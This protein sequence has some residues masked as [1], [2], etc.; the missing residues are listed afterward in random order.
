MT[1]D[2]K[3]LTINHNTTLAY[4][5]LI[6]CATKSFIHLGGCLSH[7]G[8]SDDGGLTADAGMSFGCGS[9]VKFSNSGSL[10]HLPTRTPSRLQDLLGTVFLCGVSGSCFGCRFHHFLPALRRTWSPSSLGFVPISTQVSLDSGNIPA[11]ILVAQVAV[12]SLG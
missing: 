1:L 6:Y 2:P 7:F 4:E 5:S 9:G 12:K 11:V 10:T 3:V 8:L